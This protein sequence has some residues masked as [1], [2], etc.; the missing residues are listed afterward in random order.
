M[1]MLTEESVERVC[2]KDAAE[3]SGEKVTAEESV[4]RVYRMSL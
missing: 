2:S 4:E 3:E 1:N